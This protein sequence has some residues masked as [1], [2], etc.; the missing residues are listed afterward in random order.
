VNG[1]IAESA[2]HVRK[3]F[4]HMEFPHSQVQ[5]RICRP[6]P[7]ILPHPLGCSANPDQVELDFQSRLYFSN[8]VE[9]AQNSQ[10]STDLLSRLFELDTYSVEG[11]WSVNVCKEVPNFF[12]PKKL[13]QVAVQCPQNIA[14][15]V[16]VGVWFFVAFATIVM[17]WSHTNSLDWNPAPAL[18]TL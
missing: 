17:R 1:K 12:C 4:C 15:Q 14:V 13:L 16:E 5:L 8:S 9:Q 2:S 3:T 10:M 7:L 6:N 11:T 18:A